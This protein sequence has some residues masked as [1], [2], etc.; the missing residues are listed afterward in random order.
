MNRGRTR[1]DVTEGCP[2]KIDMDFIRWIWNYP[3]VSKPRILRL[4][5]KLRKSKNVYILNN[6]WEIEKFLEALKTRYTRDDLH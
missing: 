3:S 2:E 4:L 1:S 5:E 6:Q